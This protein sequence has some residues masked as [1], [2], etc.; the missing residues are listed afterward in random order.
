MFLVTDN[1]FRRRQV[2]VAGELT[3]GT[4]EEGS[5]LMEVDKTS[6]RDRAA[7]LGADRRLREIGMGRS[8]CQTRIYRGPAQT[9]I[10]GGQ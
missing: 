8:I 7:S 3:G 4:A 2:P 6:H 5:P 9:A 10:S 1:E